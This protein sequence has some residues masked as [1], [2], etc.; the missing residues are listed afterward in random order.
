MIRSLVAGFVC[1][2]FICAG[3]V[4]AGFVFAGSG[5]AATAQDKKEPSKDPK[6]QVA[7]VVWEREAEGIDLQFEFTPEVLTV[8]AMLGENGFAAR[9][10]ITTSKDGLMKVK[11]VSVKEIGSPPA[12]PS[13]GDEFSFRWKVNGDTAELSDLRGENVEDAKSVVE[14]EYKKKKKKK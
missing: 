4:C 13:V 10:K 2:G 5:V 1:A 3:F 6:G 11:I 14:G 8:T 9:C 7:P 12:K